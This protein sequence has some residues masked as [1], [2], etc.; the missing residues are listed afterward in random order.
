MRRHVIPVGL[1]GAG[2][3]S[4]SVELARRLGCIC[5]NADQI[6]EERVGMDIS[7]IF[8]VH[9]EDFFRV[10]EAAVVEELLALPPR[11][12]SP[13]GGWIMGVRDFGTIKSGALIIYLKTDPAQ[14]VARL[15]GALDRPLLPEG[16]IEEMAALLARRGA[17]YEAAECALVTDGLLVAEVVAKAHGLAQ[18]RAGW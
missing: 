8:R 12:I 16:S 9:G 10:H 17:S 14:A 3:T 5:A 4:V 7:S 15:E 6:V 2:K 18:D 13:G 1:P 11:V